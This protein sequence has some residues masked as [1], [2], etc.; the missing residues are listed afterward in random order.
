[1]ILAE[2]L[3]LHNEFPPTELGCVALPELDYEMGASNSVCTDS[4]KAPRCP[5]SQSLDP[6]LS[7]RVCHWVCRE[8]GERELVFL[9]LLLF[10][11]GGPV[12]YNLEQRAAT[13]QA[14]GAMQLLQQ[15]DQMENKGN[16]ESEGRGLSKF[17]RRY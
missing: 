7:S 17:W 13:R 5:V 8:C 15:M 11:T 3:F 12:G 2:T 6:S 14:E 10:R 4:L 1:M 9:F 16:M